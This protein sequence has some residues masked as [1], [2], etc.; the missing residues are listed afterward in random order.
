[1]PRYRLTEE[2]RRQMKEAQLTRCRNP[3][4]ADVVE[5]NICTV[6]QMREEHERGKSRQDRVADA[7]TALSGSMLFVYIHALWFGLW[8]LY[9]LGAFGFKPFDPFPF[10]LLTMIVSLEAIFLSTFILVSQNRMSLVA[11]RRADLDLQIN[12]LAEHEIT[13]ILTLVDAIAREMKIVRPDP[14]VEEL[15]RDVPPEV[16]LKEMEE[17][18]QERAAMN[19]AQTG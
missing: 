8:V 13:R 12:L 9:N 19:G 1:M 15:K 5:R 7:I 17:R 3:N 4:L 6:I 2:V 11:D 16:V 18:E 14:E 10:G